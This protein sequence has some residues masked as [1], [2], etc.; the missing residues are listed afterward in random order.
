MFINKSSFWSRKQTK[1]AN[2]MMRKIMNF[3]LLGLL[4]FGLVVP[5]SV[6]EGQLS[7]SPIEDKKVTVGEKVEF[8]IIV[9]GSSGEVV[10]KERHLPSK[11]EITRRGPH[12]FNFQWTPE[13]S[14]VGEK[15]ILFWVCDEKQCS[16]EEFVQI[17]VLPK[18]GGDGGSQTNDGDSDGVND[19]VDNCPAVSNPDQAD[20]DGDGLGDA[21][22]GSDDS[23]GDTSN[24]DNEGETI[25]E[26]EYNELKDK[27]DVYED[28]YFYYKKKYEKAVEADDQDDIEKYEDK[29]N[30]LDD[31]LKELKEDVNDLIDDLE[32]A[33]DKD[34]DLLDD[35]DKL[36]D[37]VI[38]LRKKI[39]NLLESEETTAADSDAY[40][41]PPDEEEPLV[42]IESLDMSGLDADKGEEQL[43]SAKWDELRYTVWLIAGII[44]LIAVIFF[45][46][47]LLLK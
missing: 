7:I 12:A 6:A 34:E 32:D 9:H 46:L 41:A 37:D 13:E 10:L 18:R 26:D 1:G 35:L 11:A 44:V 8:A 20:T 19:D 36:K 42:V 21:C 39:G 45:L 27:Y 14:D 30:D 23:S 40:V 22:D 5:A 43:K 31:G 3:L 33:D 24:G 47:A 16:S 2:K 25:P 29:L 28:D 15:A 38:D 17:T 4:L